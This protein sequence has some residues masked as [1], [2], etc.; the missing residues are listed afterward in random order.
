MTEYKIDPLDISFEPLAGSNFTNLLRLLAQNKFKIGVIGIPRLLYSIVLSLFL[1]PLSF[2]E[3][4]TTHKKIKNTKIEKTPIFI[5][6][7][8]RSRTTY[9]HNLMSQN[10]DFAYPTTFQTITPG[11]FLKFEK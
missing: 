7:H 8:W 3:K 11:I 5:I 9:L 1:S 4:I 10:L 2:Y 6:G